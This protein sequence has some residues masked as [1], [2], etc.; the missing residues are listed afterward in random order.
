MCQSQ[1]FM[2][3]DILKNVVHQISW[4]LRVSVF[5]FVSLEGSPKRCYIKLDSLLSSNL[6]SL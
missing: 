1:H 6:L 2:K 4:P 5:V 3:H